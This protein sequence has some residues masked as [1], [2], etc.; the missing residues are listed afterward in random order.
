MGGRQ[1]RELPPDLARAAGRFAQWRRSR[2]LGER[3]PES[4]WNHAVDLASRHGVSRTASVLSVGYRELQKR[5]ARQPIC[6]GEESPP[7]MA[8]VELPP[9]V[10][11]G[12]CVIEFENAL[13]SRMRVQLKGSQLPDLVALGRSF[14]DAR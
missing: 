14:W 3:I 11:A 7:P 10:A 5:V 8:F 4:L 6:D 1:R 2:V 13:G 12:E 9:A